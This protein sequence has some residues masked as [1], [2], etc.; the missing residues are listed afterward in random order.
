MNWGALIDSWMGRLL[1]AVAGAYDALAA[2]WGGLRAHRTIGTLLVLVFLAALLVIHLGRLNL[3][4]PA[5]ARFIPHN[6]F[7]A[8]AIAFWLLLNVEI[9]AL[10]FS[11][12]ESVANSVG[13]QFELFSLILIRKA[14]LEFGEFGGPIEWPQ[15][16]SSM[17]VMLS[18]LLGALLI[19]VAVGLYYR[20]QRHR[21]I[22]L[23]ERE[24]Q[25]FVAAKKAVAL[26][27]FISFVL[28]ASADVWAFITGADTFD[29]FQL[30]YTVLVFSDVLIV[31]ISIAYTSG[32]HVVFRNSGFAAATIM[33]RLALAAPAYV[34]AA[35]G[36]GAAL[37]A[38]GL[39]F[40]Y[41][42]FAPAMHDRNGG[43]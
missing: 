32:Y 18:D 2:W 33:M 19:F 31:L 41:N 7:G 13:K 36:L 11:L 15:A 5:V 8:V 29:F 26:A 28:L 30:F 14:F 34:N 22:T 6:Y 17:L 40:A 21:P 37:F 16:S 43:R 20:L 38:V 24:Q 25:S 42:N 10:V 39:S 4:P 35:L 23:D 9:L 3:L 27:L 1:S 12:A